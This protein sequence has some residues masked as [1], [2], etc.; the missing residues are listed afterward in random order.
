MEKQKS[1]LADICLQ[2]AAIA[3]KDLPISSPVNIEIKVELPKL[4]K[5]AL[6]NLRKTPYQI[7]LEKSK[8]ETS[9]D[10]QKDCPHYMSSSAALYRTNHELIK[11]DL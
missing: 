6:S 9:K 8:S 1:D 5:E 3:S 2:E 7:Q 4:S 10:Q 11:E